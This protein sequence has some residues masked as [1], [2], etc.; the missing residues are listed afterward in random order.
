MDHEALIRDLLPL[1]GEED[2]IHI[3]VRPGDEDADNP[4]VLGIAIL[5]SIEPW[6]GVVNWAR[7]TFRT[8]QPN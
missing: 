6:P 1:L 4:D 7:G 8:S 2:R 5:S 3:L